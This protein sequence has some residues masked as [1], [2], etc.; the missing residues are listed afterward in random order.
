V[1]FENITFFEDNPNTDIKL[2]DL[3]NNGKT[4][5]NFSELPEKIS[6]SYA[7]V[8]GDN[9][10]KTQSYIEAYGLKNGDNKKFGAKSSLD[11]DF[12]FAKGEYKDDENTAEKIFNSIF[13][14]LTGL[15]K[16]YKTQTGSRL[17]F[18]KLEQNTIPIDT[19][20]IKESD[21]R[22]SV[23]TDVLLKPEPLFNQHYVN[24]SP[25]NNQFSIVKS[26][27]VQPICGV[28]TNVLIENNVIRDYEGRSIIVT[29]NLRQSQDGLYDIEY[30]RRMQNNDFGFVASDLIEVVKITVEG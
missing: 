1:I 13:D 26:R 10:Y 15:S 25:V 21:G 11:V 3:Y 14:L 7:Q 18:W 19:I 23:K 28:D 29:K 9:N 30:R 20:F 17:G 22:M 4:S 5:F 2:L 24:E 16:G 6:L 27:G 12:P 8:D